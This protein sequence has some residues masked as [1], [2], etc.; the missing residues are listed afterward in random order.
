MQGSGD[1]FA[2]DKEHHVHCADFLNVLEMLAVQPQNL[3]VAFLFGLCT[4]KDGAGIVAAGLCRAGTAADCANVFVF[5]AD[6]DGCKACLVVRTAGRADDVVE[7]AVCGMYAE[8]FVNRDHR[9][10]QIEACAC[11]VGYPVTFN[12]NELT[13]CLIVEIDVDFGHAETPCGIVKTLCIVL[14][15][16]HQDP[17]VVGTICLKAFENLLCIVKHGAGRIERKSLIGNDACIV[18]F[19]VVIVHHE[20][21]VGETFAEPEGSFFLKGG[22]CFKLGCFCD[23]DI[24]FCSS[25][26][27][28]RI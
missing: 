25:C 10:T 17:A 11:A 14:C 16:E 7:V 27:K 15:T 5:N 12:L 24:H 4:C 13:H 3:A 2:V 28:K 6:A 8:S 9:G 1:K 20:H 23:L 26:F 18:P 21:M 19:A 22:F